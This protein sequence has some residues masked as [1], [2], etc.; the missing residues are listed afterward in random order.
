MRE[1]SQTLAHS[2]ALQPTPLLAARLVALRSSTASEAIAFMSSG[3]TEKVIDGSAVDAFWEAERAWQREALEKTMQ[4]N[5]RG[6]GTDAAGR[7]R[8]VPARPQRAPPR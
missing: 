7:K 3:A 4:V 6:R 5:V 8:A 2:C 1:N